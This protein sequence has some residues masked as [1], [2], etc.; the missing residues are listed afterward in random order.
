MPTGFLTIAVLINV[1]RWLILIN[2]YNKLKKYSIDGNGNHMAASFQGPEKGSK[3][4]TYNILLIAF[5]FIAFIIILFKIIYQ[6]GARTKEL[7]AEIENYIFLLMLFTLNL[8]SLIIYI[9]A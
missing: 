3:E 7:Q 1:T 4:R 8:V 6:C 2:S 9:Y 5:S